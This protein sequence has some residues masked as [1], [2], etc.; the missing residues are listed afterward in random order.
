VGEMMT[1]SLSLSLTSGV[2]EHD[3]R[4]MMIGPASA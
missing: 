4:E 1:L 2:G 3:M